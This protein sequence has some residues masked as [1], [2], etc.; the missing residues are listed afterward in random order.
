VVFSLL[1]VNLLSD[2]PFTSYPDLVE[3]L[4][5]RGMNIPKS[6]YGYVIDALKSRSYYGLIN[7]FKDGL[8]YRDDAGKEH[9]NSGVNFSDLM[10]QYWIEN[11]LK[12]LLLKYSLLAETRLKELTA[13]ALAD[14]FGESMDS[15]LA[16]QHFSNRNRKR[17]SI[18]RQI[19]HVGETTENN[20]TKYYR[21]RHD[22]IPPWI[23][24]SNLMLGEFRSLYGILKSTE[25][26][27]VVR[28]IMYIPEE[29]SIK[30]DERGFVKSSLAILNDFRNT[31]AHGSRLIKY[32]ATHGSISYDVIKSI[33]GS[34]L[35]SEHE[36][37]VNK[38]GRDDLFCLICVIMKNC[39]RIDSASFQNELQTWLVSM[40]NNFSGENQFKKYYELTGLPQD[41][42]IKLNIMRA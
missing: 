12:S 31:L 28:N 2:R 23:L 4:R 26:D 22:E 16:N 8:V 20:P 27:F 14:S 3:K 40:A 11:E 7:A 9:F 25:K 18:L 42:N 1:E 32:N 6:Q 5:K 30:D 17:D 37:T 36:Y 24:F 13:H 19:K 41:L 21:N 35:L 29:Q 15:Y 10:A 34:T 38:N 33:F 39:G